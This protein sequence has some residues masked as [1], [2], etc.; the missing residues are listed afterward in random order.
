MIIEPGL[1]NEQITVC[2]YWTIKYN[3]I[4]TSAPNMTTYRCCFDQIVLPSFSSL[5]KISP[6]R[7]NISA[8]ESGPMSLSIEGEVSARLLWEA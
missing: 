7:S 5:V 1:I 3:A 8:L 4:L 6:W 2:I